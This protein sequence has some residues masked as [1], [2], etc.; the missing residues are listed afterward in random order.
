MSPTTREQFTQ[1]VMSQ[2]EGID[3]AEVALLIAK[4]EYPDLDVSRYLARLDGMAEE[5]RP[6]VEGLSDPRDTIGALNDFI[7]EQEGFRGN[8]A[9]YY[10][11]GN[12]FLN[13]VLDR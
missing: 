2:E 6:R 7:F 5:V 9:D 8:E 4:E 3:L 10:D 1:A 13:D 12:S 11:P